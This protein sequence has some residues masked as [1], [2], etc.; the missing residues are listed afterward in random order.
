MNS[1]GMDFKLVLLC[2]VNHETVT[3][4]PGVTNFPISCT[5]CVLNSFIIMLSFYMLAPWQI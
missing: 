2:V 3:S 1:V 5:L 4:K